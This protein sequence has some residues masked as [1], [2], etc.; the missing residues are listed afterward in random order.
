MLHVTPIIVIH[1][2]LAVAGCL[3]C[4][5]LMQLSSKHGELADLGGLEVA[6]WRLGFGLLGISLAWSL[7][8][9][10]MTGRQPFAGHVMLIATLD[11]AMVFRI[12]Q[13]V[14][15]CRHLKKLGKNFARP[16]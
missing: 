1:G 2:V 5:A 4:I 16:V 11:V 8:D 12:G 13:I 7:E 14:S 15:R 9:A 3:L 6:V 10:A